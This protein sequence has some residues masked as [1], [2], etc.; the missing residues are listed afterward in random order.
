MKLM[1]F[2]GLSLLLLTF[3]PTTSL[4]QTHS[5]APRAEGELKGLVL[6][7]NSSRVAGAKITLENKR[8]RFEVWSN[9]EGA[10]EVKAPVGEYQL[11]IESNG[12]KDYIKKRVRIEADKTETIKAT[13]VIQSPPDVIKLQ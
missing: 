7:S 4:A 5:P 9:D 8:Y 2:A 3:W 11:K 10:F 12:F 6:D 13:V 1:V